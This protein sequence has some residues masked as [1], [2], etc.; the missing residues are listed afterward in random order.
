MNKATHNHKLIYKK[1]AAPKASSC[2]SWTRTWTR[3]TW[4]NP[5][6]PSQSPSTSDRKKLLALL[7]HELRKVI[8]HNTVKASYSTVPNMEHNAKMWKNKK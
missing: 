1:S 5:P 7:N 8:D 3:L 4:F 6:T 2:R